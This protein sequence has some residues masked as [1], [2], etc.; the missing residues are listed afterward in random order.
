MAAPKRDAN[1]LAA[2]DQAR[3]AAE[4]QAGDWGVGEWLEA[5][6][7]ADLVLTHY[8]ACPHPGYTGWRWAV[9]M[10]RVPRGRTATVN[11]VV[12]LPG[13]G[14]LLA[15][16][17]VPWSD[18][19]QAGDVHPGTV[20]PTAPDDP[21]LEPGYTGGELSADDDPAEWSQTRAL[22]AELG[23]GRERVLSY[24]GRQRAAERWL[25]G[26]GGPH[27]QTTRL[28]PGEC[29]TCGYFVRLGGALGNLFGVCANEFSPSD[30]RVVSVDHG[31]GGHS[32][33]VV[34]SRGDFELSEPY[35]DT[36]TIDHP[37]FE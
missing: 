2:V 34:Q 31:C 14:S 1:L 18:R 11:E 25:A 10:T 8:F 17:W 4:E 23:L 3:Q 27:N 26:D 37:L 7:E 15:P 35:F 5:V 20:L 13:A 22:V 19:L 36:I 16:P 33:A 29:V 32:D 28:A 12:L 30:G 6:A 24:T 9:T 21:R